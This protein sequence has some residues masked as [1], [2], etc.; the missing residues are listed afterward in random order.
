MRNPFQGSLEAGDTGKGRSVAGL[1][2]T[3]MARALRDSLLELGMGRGLRDS[4]L[5]L[6]M[7]SSGATSGSAQ[8]NDAIDGPKLKRGGGVTA[9]RAV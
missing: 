2:E 6:R 7:R 5:E 4:L 3:M 8:Q 1:R 9:R